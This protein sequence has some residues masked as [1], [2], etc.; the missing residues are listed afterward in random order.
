MFKAQAVASP[1]RLITRDEYGHPPPTITTA[2]TTRVTTTKSAAAV[3]TIDHDE[4]LKD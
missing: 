4:E 3:V 1:R 2:M